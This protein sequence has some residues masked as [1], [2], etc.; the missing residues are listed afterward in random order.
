M[1]MDMYIDKV[2]RNPA[3]KLEVIERTNLCYWRKFW[4][5]HYELGLYGADDYGNDVPMT[6]ADVERAIDFATRNEDYW[7]GFDSVPKLCELLRDFDE[8]KNQGYEVVYN[9]NW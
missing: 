1:G 5:L 7:G 2:R 3:N 6:K 8:Y 4:D 9:A